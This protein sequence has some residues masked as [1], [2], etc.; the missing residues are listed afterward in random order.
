MTI[1]PLCFDTEQTVQERVTHYFEE[2]VFDNVIEA[3]KK[4]DPDAPI[5]LLLEDLDNA[6][7]DAPKHLERIF[8]SLGKENRIPKLLVKSL[9]SFLAKHQLKGAWLLLAYIAPFVAQ[10]LDA[11][12]A[13]SCWN[14][15]KDIKHPEL[16]EHK[17]SVLKVIG[18]LASYLDKKM[19]T[20]LSS[21]LI[22]RLERF[23]CKASLIQIFT[24]TAMTVS[25]VP[26]S[27]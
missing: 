10:H 9:H 21:D 24:Q 27:P 6:S 23:D 5:W 3:S 14:K 8:S 17:V 22:S 4:N 20:N 11:D 13:V 18:A 12:F 26:I 15:V 7:P 1:P 25:I 19:V 2:I 16:D